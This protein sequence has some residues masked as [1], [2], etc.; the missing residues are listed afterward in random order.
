MTDNEIIETFKDN[1][2]SC[3]YCPYHIY[4]DCDE[5]NR[6]DILDLIKRQQA[7]IERLTERN[8]NLSEKGEK[9]CIALKTAKAEAIKEYAERLK[10][11]SELMAMSVYAAPER[12]VF[13]SDIDNLVK[14]I[15]GGENNG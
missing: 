14:E 1:C 7:E 2:N 13:V 9:V 5:R 8:F 15:T 10:R 3:E 12:A 4:S 6:K 11:K